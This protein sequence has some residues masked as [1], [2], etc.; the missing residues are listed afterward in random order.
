MGTS[1]RLAGMWTL[2]FAV[3][4]FVVLLFPS[5]PA[6][7]AIHN[8]NGW[9]WSGTTGWLSTNCEDPKPGFPTGDCSVGN[10]NYGLDIDAT[11][12]LS[13]WAWSTQAG[14]I[15]VG[16]TCNGAG[17]VPA[18]GTPAQDHY[19]SAHTPCARYEPSDSAFHGWAYVISETDGANYRGWVSLNCTDFDPNVQLPHGCPPNPPGP[20]N[21][22]DFHVD[23]DETSGRLH[24]YAWNGNGDQTGNGWVQIACGWPRPCGGASGDWGVTTSW[25]LSGWSSVDQQEGVYSPPPPGGTP[26]I[27]LTTIPIVFRNFSAP[28]GSTLACYFR[29]SDGSNQSSSWPIAARQANVA[30]YEV[31]YAISGSDKVADVSGNP[32]LWSFSTPVGVNPPYGCQII[33]IPPAKLSVANLIAIHPWNWSFSGPGGSLQSDSNRAKYCLDGNLGTD[34]SRAYFLNTAQ[35]DTEGDLAQT[36]L[37]SKGIS[38]QVHCRS[39]VDEDLNGQIDYNGACN[40]AIPLSTSDRNCRGLTYLCISHPAAPSGQPPLP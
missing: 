38:V 12:N 19:C 28:A 6:R 2:V 36:L 3:G 1:K 31:D 32:V 35:C 26:G 20:L 11:G 22:Q 30:S 4:L 13:G 16:G 21:S 27:F 10:N 7:A 29:E 25:A 23:F 33:G 5:T 8:V 24:G 18:A 34:P 15:C 17:G 9:A 37:R 40:A 14:W 39:G